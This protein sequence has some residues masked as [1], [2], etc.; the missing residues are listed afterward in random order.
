MYF[1]QRVLVNNS[2]EKNQK[3]AIFTKIICI[4]VQNTLVN[5][6]SSEDSL[7]VIIFR[8]TLLSNLNRYDTDKQKSIY[9]KSKRH[10]HQ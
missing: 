10:Y 5:Y 7:L 4:F 1:Q 3:H 9:Q 2:K 8:E 6:H